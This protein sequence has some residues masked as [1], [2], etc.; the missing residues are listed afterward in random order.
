MQG[1]T[2]FRI[3]FDNLFINNPF[4][5]AISAFVNFCNEQS[6]FYRQELK[7]SKKMPFTNRKETCSYKT[8]FIFDSNQASGVSFK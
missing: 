7:F 3:M 2:F 5:R 6:V 8:R 4:C 1:R